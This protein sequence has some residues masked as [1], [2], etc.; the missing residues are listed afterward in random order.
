MLDADAVRGRAAMH[1]RTQSLAVASVVEFVDAQECAG[2][3]RCGPGRFCAMLLLSPSRPPEG[4]CVPC[5]NM[6]PEAAAAAPSDGGHDDANQLAPVDNQSTWRTL[7]A[8]MP[9]IP[10]IF[11]QLLPW[12]LPSEACALGD[13][14]LDEFADKMTTDVT[15]QDYPGHCPEGAPQNWCEWGPCRDDPPLT[16]AAQLPRL[17]SWL[18]QNGTGSLPVYVEQKRQ[19]RA[20]QNASERPGTMEHD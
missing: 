3:A 20:Q 12:G 2:H 16:A 18:R 11:S 19:E 10:S 17:P 15:R 7:L 4:R 1:A 13:D 5:S 6:R 8:V 14:L 9:H